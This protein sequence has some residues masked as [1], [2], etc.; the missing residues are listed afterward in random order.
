MN[1]LRGNDELIAIFYYIHRLRRRLAHVFL[2]TD[3]SE[4][5]AFRFVIAGRQAKNLLSSFPP[6]LKTIVR[7]PTVS[8][9]ELSLFLCGKSKNAQAKTFLSSFPPWLKTIVRKPRHRVLH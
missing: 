7:K 4:G 3:Y 5:F 8:N 6:W 2:I 9:P 1:P